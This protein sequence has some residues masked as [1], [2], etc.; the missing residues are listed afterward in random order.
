MSTTY[1]NAVG[2]Q[3]RAPQPKPGLVIPV[4]ACASLVFGLQS[5]TQFFAY[6]FQYQA[7]LGEHVGALYQPWAILE[8]AWRWAHDYPLQLRQAGGVGMI[9]A[10]SGLRGLARIPFSTARPAGPTETTSKLPRCSLDLE[11]SWIG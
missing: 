4:L 3:V 11:R 5:A 7:A 9:V 2:P 1:N 6:T 10:A 8:W